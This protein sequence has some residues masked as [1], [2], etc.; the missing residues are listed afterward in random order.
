[1]DTYVLKYPILGLPLLK[2]SFAPTE[3]S[4]VLDFSTYLAMGVRL[5]GRSTRDYSLWKYGG[6]LGMLKMMDEH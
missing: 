3:L 1:M 6:N 5:D 4:P 2:P